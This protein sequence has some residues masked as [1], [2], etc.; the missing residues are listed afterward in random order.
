MSHQFIRAS[1]VEK[2]A[3]IWEVEI[4][5]SYYGLYDFVE[6]KLCSDKAAAIRWLLLERTG[7]DKLRIIDIAGLNV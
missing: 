2:L 7:S 3:G 4:V 6:T 1:I 5:Y